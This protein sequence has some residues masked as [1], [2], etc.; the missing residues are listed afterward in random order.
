[1]IL[2]SEKGVTYRNDILKEKK[3]DVIVSDTFHSSRLL[4]TKNWN[5]A[6]TA[7]CLT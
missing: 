5:A 4:P 1:M 2:R 6:H 3:T 7:S